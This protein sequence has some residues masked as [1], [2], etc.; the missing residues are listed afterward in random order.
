MRAA[1]K[2]AVRGGEGLRGARRCES[3]SRLR[4]GPVA[5][6]HHFRRAATGRAAAV[7]IITSCT[8]ISGM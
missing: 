4:I 8:V 5:L 7:H 2:N 3:L 6:T 1:S